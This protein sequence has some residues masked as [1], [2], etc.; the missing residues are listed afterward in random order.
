MLPSLP[1]PR[2]LT[3]LVEQ[4]A[5][6]LPRV[7]GLLDDAEALLRKADALIDRIEQTRSA[8]DDV[9]ERTDAVVTDAN[10]LIVRSAGTLGSVE[11]TLERAQ[12][13][14]DTFGPLLDDLSPALKDLVPTITRLAESTDPDEVEALVRLVDQV[15]LLVD[16]LQ[17]DI[18]P[19][20]E[21][22]STVGPDIHAMLAAIGDLAD[23][24]EKIPGLNRRRRNAER[25]AE[26]RAADLRPDDED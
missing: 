17:A 3:A 11:P 9:V 10:A 15:P 26:Q 8:A 20:M 14:L 23:M 7:L 21:S 6:A 25:E 4:L 18:V 1:D 19:I 5:G 22:M 24:L 16:K 12:K 13:M 2:R